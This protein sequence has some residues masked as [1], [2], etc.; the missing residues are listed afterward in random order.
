M[1]IIAASVNG[2]NLAKWRDDVNSSGL[3]VDREAPSTASPSSRR[4]RGR[5]PSSPAAPAG[6]CRTST[7][8]T[9]QR[10]NACRTPAGAR[11]AASRSRS[12]PASRKVAQRARFFCLTFTGRAH[13]GSASRFR[14]TYGFVGAGVLVVPARCR[15]TRSLG[16]CAPNDRRTSSSDLFRRR[17]RSLARRG[18][19]ERVNAG[20]LAARRASAR[21]RPTRLHRNNESFL[22]LEGSS[23]RF[24]Q[25]VEQAV[26]AAR[27]AAQAS[28]WRR[29]RSRR[30]HS[31][32]R[33]VSDYGSSSS[34]RWR[35]RQR[36]ASAVRSETGEPRARRF[37]IVR[38]CGARWGEMQLEER[39]RD[40]RDARALR[41]RDAGRTRRPT[42]AR[43]RPDLVVRAARR[44][45]RR[46]RR[47]VAAQGSTSSR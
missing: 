33:A 30:K 15:P 9:R 5:R 19:R 11:P 14:W 41:L 13:L 6:S 2:L 20:R 21:L 35:A 24:E 34:N 36:P 12:A 26:V 46:R 43:L 7:A 31:S 17:R 27:A 4:C 8:A 32:D 28:P 22:E 38:R 25:G 3:G 10:A 47:E 23:G 37:A 1:A 18:S 29:S 39:R 45:A 16:F 44:P 40:G 42:G